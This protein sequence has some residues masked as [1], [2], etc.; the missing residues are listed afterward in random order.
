MASSGSGR[1]LEESLKVR[2]LKYIEGMRKVLSE[3]KVVGRSV[4]VDPSKVDY[5]LEWT[6]SY[7]EDASTFLER[8]D[9]ASCLVA[10]CYA[11]GLVEAL[12]LLGLAEFEW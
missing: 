4:M 3:I 11:E 6:R 5:L 7:V 1:T 12:R 9:L 2:A 10:V 8:D